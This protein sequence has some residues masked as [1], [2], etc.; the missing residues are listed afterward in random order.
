M[1]A[2]PLRKRRISPI[3]GY[4]RVM[5][6][7]VQRGDKVKVNSIST[8]YIWENAHG[9]IGYD[10]NGGIATGYLVYRKEGA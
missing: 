1:K 9:I 7:V 4:Y 8:D 5:S 2:R 3:F 10:I 6:G